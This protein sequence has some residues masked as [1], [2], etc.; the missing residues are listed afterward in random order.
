MSSQRP[1]WG[2]GLFFFLLQLP[3]E[4]LQQG[5]DCPEEQEKNLTDEKNLM[6]KAGEGRASCFPL[7]V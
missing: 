1:M 7:P 4:W 2:D 6:S 3:N 5:K